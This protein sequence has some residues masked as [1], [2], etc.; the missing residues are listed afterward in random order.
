MPAVY[1]LRNAIA[2][3]GDELLHGL[4]GAQTLSLLRT[5]DPKLSSPAALRDLVLAEYETTELLRRPDVKRSII[6]ALPLESATVLA[7]MLGCTGADPYVALAG[8]RF[9]RGSAQERKLFDFFDVAGDNDE[10]V[11]RS[12]DSFTVEPVSG[13][14]N[15]QRRA[16]RDVRAYLDSDSPTVLLHMPTGSG[17]TRTA[18]HLI[19]DELNDHEGT[20]VLW[21]AFNEELCEQ[22]AQEFQRAW[23]ASGNR[24][25]Q[26]VRYW[27]SHNGPLT[28]LRDGVAVLGLQK[29][30]SM[31]QQGGA[32][33][34]AGA[35]ARLIVI[36]E[37][38]SAV[39]ETYRAVL[40]ILTHAGSQSG[41]LGLT[42]TPGR[43]WDD[44][45]ADEELAEFFGRNK[46]SLHIDGYE[47]P[48]HYLVDEGYL[49]EVE[50]RRINSP[51]DPLSPD[52]VAAIEAALEIPSR[53]LSRLS[54]DQQRNLAILMEVESLVRRGHRRILLFATTV[55]HCRV[56][57]MALRMRG[58]HAASVTASTR[59]DDR[60]RHIDAFRGNHEAP[61]VLVNF[62][63]L[64]TGFDAPRTSAALIARPTRSLV[65]YSQMVGRVTRGPKAG[66]NAKAEVVTVVDPGLPGF[67]DM[68][69][70]F[71]NWEDV[72]RQQ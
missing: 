57:S 47:N 2:R 31:V 59:A 6:E 51:S 19:V 39:A 14:F 49:A 24:S 45:A 65:L 27:G 66:G 20:T 70:A 41:L 1:D 18:M 61:M 60:K 44:I 50:Y 33:E 9:A 36:D 64:T 63:V 10:V 43:T 3:A 58:L 17:K 13:L 72:W 38:H 40:T 35:R 67:G 5:L 48:V 16:V 26:L 56:L 62:G 34:S 28:E 37:A 42:A 23:S 69:E 55:D 68:A 29:A 7:D 22:A 21:L 4:V 46:V 12:P 8:L 53:V 11:E 32:L 25:V 52:D 30:Y 54:D 71:E 15:H